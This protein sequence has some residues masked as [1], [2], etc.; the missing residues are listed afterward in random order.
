M[1]GGPGKAP[2]QILRLYAKEPLARIACLRW[3]LFAVWYLLEPCLTGASPCNGSL[4]TAGRPIS[5]HSMQA[6]CQNPAPLGLFIPQSYAVRLLNFCQSSCLNLNVENAP[7]SFFLPSLHPRDACTK[8]NRERT[9]TTDNRHEA[10]HS[11]TSLAD[12]E[13]NGVLPLAITSK[14]FGPPNLTLTDNI[15]FKSS[16]CYCS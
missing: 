1:R 16:C 3:P 11:E 6:A 7:G 10:A 2:L 15:R 14:G 5:L 13:P 4:P 8:R 12:L 9:C